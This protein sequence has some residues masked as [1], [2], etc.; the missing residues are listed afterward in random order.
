MEVEVE[1]TKIFGLIFF[2]VVVIFLLIVFIGTFLNKSKTKNVINGKKFYELVSLLDDKNLRKNALERLANIK[3]KRSIEI[4]TSFIDSLDTGDPDD[5]NIMNYAFDLISEINDKTVLDFMITTLQGKEILKKYSA[6]K[7]ISYLVQV[8]KIKAKEFVI[9]ILSLVKELQELKLKNSQSYNKEI[10]E[11]AIIILNELTGKD[12]GKD[13]EKWE[14][15][16][17]QNLKT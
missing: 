1:L 8:K 3:D 4:I 11:I 13:T 6:L 7:K 5:R 17:S 14:E 10:E 9:P 15:W 16:V 2:L 12:F